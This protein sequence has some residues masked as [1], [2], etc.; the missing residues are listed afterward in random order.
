LA[1]K[2][3]TFRGSSFRISIFRIMTLRMAFFMITVSTAAIHGL[4]YRDNYYQDILQIIFW[5][6]DDNIYYRKKGRRRKQ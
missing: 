3:S 2:V 5:D 4:N 6:R 1:L